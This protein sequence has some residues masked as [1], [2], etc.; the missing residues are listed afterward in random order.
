MSSF[1]AKSNDLIAV[2]VCNQA[3]AIKSAMHEHFFFLFTGGFSL[4]TF[5]RSLFLVSNLQI[6]DLIQDKLA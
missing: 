1:V 5:A 2:Q 4:T 3:L 6:T